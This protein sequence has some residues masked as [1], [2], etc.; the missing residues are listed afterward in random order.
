MKRFAPSNEF[1][2]HSGSQILNLRDHRILQT[3]TNQLI[4][5]DATFHS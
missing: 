5:C 3:T 2:A 4:N 1:C